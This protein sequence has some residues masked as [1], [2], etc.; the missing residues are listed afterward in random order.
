MRYIENSIFIDCEWSMYGEIFLISY[1][2][3]FNET[4]PIYHNDLFNFPR[5]IKKLNPNFIFVFGPD[6]SYIDKFF[7][8]DFRN[9]FI[10]INVLTMS[11][12][13]IKID[14]HKLSSLEN[15]LGINR[16][17]K[18][19]KENIFNIWEDWN[20][21]FFRE[22]IIK[23]NIQDVDSLHTITSYCIDNFGLTEDNIL[24]YRLQ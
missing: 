6:I 24:E 19:Y 22:M 3:G 20:N 17:I 9:N 13:L 14:S 15:Y 23:Y 11:R 16:E 5:I 10:C 1:K 18:K 8:E 12:R 2:Y 4:Q 21:E 7:N